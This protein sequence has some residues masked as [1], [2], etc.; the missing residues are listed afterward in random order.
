MDGIFNW[1]LALGRACLR[2]H[3]DDTNLQMFI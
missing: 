3:R 1:V 2:Y